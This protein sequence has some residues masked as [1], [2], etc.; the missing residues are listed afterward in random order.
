MLVAERVLPR[1]QPFRAL[2][3]LD[4][5]ISASAIPALV[6][7]LNGAVVERLT[8]D[9][10]SGGDSN[11]LDP[12]SSEQGSTSDDDANAGSPLPAAHGSSPAGNADAHADAGDES[13]GADY[14]HVV[15]RGLIAIAASLPGLRV[16]QLSF[17]DDTVLLKRYILALRALTNLED[18]SFVYAGLYRNGE[19]SEVT[20]DF[21]TCGFAEL[22]QPLH[23]LRRLKLSVAADISAGMLLAVGLACPFLEEL[24]LPD[25]EYD[26]EILAHVD[27]EHTP[28]F[29]Y[30]RK[31]EVVSFDIDRHDPDS[32][33]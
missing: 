27:E 11:G 15:G 30:L 31:L 6:R 28:L 22:L 14:G 1:Q 24:Q 23:K 7:V 5:E 13:D 3:S 12:D 18:L 32:A 33:M 16:L 26:L 17:F 2:K 8:L 29:D 25:G 19:V 20:V 4:T 10:M 9:V 21:D